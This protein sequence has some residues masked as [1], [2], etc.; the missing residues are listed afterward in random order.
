MTYPEC[1]RC[2]KLSPVLSFVGNA[3]AS[4]FKVVVGILTG[5]KGLAA[6][7]VHS[8]ADAV[9]SLFILLALKIA[10]K[11]HDEKHPFGYGKVEYISTLS[12]SIFLFM[13]ATTIFIDALKTFSHGVHNIPDNAAILA[14]LVSLCFSYVMYTSN[15]CAGTELGSPALVADAY[16][17]KADSISSAAVLAGLIGTK[18]G[19]VYTDTIAA[20][21]VSLFIFHMSVE[22][23]LQG[24]HGLVDMAVDKETLDRI[25][26]LSL[27]VEGI[28]DVRCIKTRRMG[29]KSWVDIRLDISKDSTIA[30]VHQI[31]EKVK[32]LIMAKVEGIGGIS[33]STF[34]VKKWRVAGFSFT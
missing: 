24:V 26:G 21:I 25:V 17:S 23:F 32:D 18:I 10:E 22:M 7:G 15:K 6:D 34:P 29:Q 11:P 20:I 12:A 14:V 1:K 30:E 33:V 28:E 19:F 27:T 13:G 5:S 8:A 16:E 4:V 2:G 31:K 9:S 3:A